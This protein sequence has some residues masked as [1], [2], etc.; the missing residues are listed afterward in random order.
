RK[1]KYVSMP[2]VPSKEDTIKAGR[3]IDRIN[4]ELQPLTTIEER[5]KKFDLLLNEYYGTTSD[6]I[7]VKDLGADLASFLLP[8]QERQVIGPMPISG[9]G[10]CFLRL[11]GRRKGE[12]E[13]VKASH[14]LIKFGDNKDSAKTEAMK[15]LKEAK[16]GSNFEELARKY[17]TD[18]GSAVKGGDLGYFA[19]GSMV[20]EFEEA[21]FAAAPGEIVGPVESQ[22]GYHIIK[23]EDKKSE[24]IK[25]SEIEVKP[26][27]STI[28]K[29]II[30]REAISIKL[31]VEEGQT[32]D[33]I[34][35]RL[36]KG[37]SETALFEKNRPVLGS[38]Y[39]T[40]KAFESEVGTVFD[41]QD[42][43]NYGLVVI[44]V[45]DTREKGIKPL[46]DVKPEI[47]RKLQIIKKLDMLKSKAQDIYQK[48]SAQGKLESI[49]SFY[50]QYFVKS[51]PELKDNGVVP[52]IGQDI[53]LT[54]TAYKIPIGQI[55]KPV[56][57][58]R[59]YY[60]MQ[61]LNRTLPDVNTIRAAMT[62][63]IKEIQKITESRLFNQWYSKMKEDADIQ[64]LRSKFFSD[65]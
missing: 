46:E 17:S 65:Y 35:H 26:K 13:V 38:Q 11:D 30:K 54:T 10:T 19:K 20:K 3:I 39:I 45:S 21:A 51:A 56:R 44:Q 41:P 22:F 59:G 16:S 37:C 40:D 14:I 25:Y 27:V 61:V 43:K 2:I 32:I 33:T 49:S 5:D 36:K 15:I 8:M 64:D 48:I 24:E 47:I 23:V 63:K 7:L 50:P 34:A 12:S 55:S 18:K 1:L 28:T 31:Q 29:N 53:V 42:L 6:Y 60:I 52:G 4:L 57:G 62:D 58:E 9:K